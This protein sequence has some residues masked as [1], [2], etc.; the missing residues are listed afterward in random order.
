MRRAERGVVLL[1]I[2]AAVLILTVAGL[3]LVALTAA[4]ARATATARERERQQMDEDRLLAAYS[5][6][7]RGGLDL[8]LGQRDV[9][10]YV[11]RVERPERV[12]YRVAVGEQRSPDVED[13]VTVLYRPAPTDA[14]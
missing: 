11:V 1:E 9:G 13:L 7:T 5:L 10:S 4:G 6:L 2:L 12:L 14:P 8:R 3:S